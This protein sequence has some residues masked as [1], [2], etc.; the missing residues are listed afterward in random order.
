MLWLGCSL[1]TLAFAI[2]I[3]S[4]AFDLPQTTRRQIC[5]LALVIAGVE[6]LLQR[7]PAMPAE[8]TRSL[9]AIVLVLLALMAAD[10]VR[11]AALAFAIFPGTP[12]AAGLGAVC[13]LLPGWLIASRID[14]RP[15]MLCRRLVGLVLVIAGIAISLVWPVWPI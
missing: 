2:W 11:L 10:P 15:G 5:A 6:G 9:G 7:S 13:G 12:S 1:V 8:P 3:A 4:H 14:R